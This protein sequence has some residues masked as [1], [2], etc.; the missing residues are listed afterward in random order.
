MGYRKIIGE[1]G[2]FDDLDNCYIY[3]R[4]LIYGTNFIVILRFEKY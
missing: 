1:K 2:Y 3:N 4:I